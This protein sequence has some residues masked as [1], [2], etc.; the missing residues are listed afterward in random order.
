MCVTAQGCES[1]LEGSV[2]R[3]IN[4]MTYLCSEPV[5]EGQPTDIDC[6]LY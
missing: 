1:H 4:M 6:V 3:F 2:Q 5:K